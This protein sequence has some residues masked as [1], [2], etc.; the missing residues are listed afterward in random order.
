MGHL[1]EAASVG[2]RS[3][4]SGKS[5]KSAKAI[6][7]KKVRTGS[8]SV[9][10]AV[11]VGVFFVALDEG[12]VFLFCVGEKPADVDSIWH[13]PVLVFEHLAEVFFGKAIAVSS[14]DLV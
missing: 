7:L 5:P 13:V 6:M 9:L 4:A 3:A 11:F 1:W 12:D 2:D 8:A 14:K 10:V